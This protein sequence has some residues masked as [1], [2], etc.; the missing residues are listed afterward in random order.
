MAQV[1]DTTPQQ[2]DINHY[3]GD[4]LT[5]RVTAP[6]SLVAGR[7]WAAQVRKTATATTVDATF[8]ITPPEVP[9][10]PAYLVLSSADCS[11]LLGIGTTVRVKDANT[12]LY[13]AQQQYT[14]FW[15]CQLSVAGADPVTT[16]VKGGITLVLDITREV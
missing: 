15:D 5:I 13:A 9:D 11:R 12:G 3:G 16:I 2:V 10:G 8:T 4:T 1:L 14:G 7:N 6:D